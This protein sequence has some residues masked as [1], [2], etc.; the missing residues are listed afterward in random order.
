MKK[1]N[2]AYWVLT[3]L[4]AAFVMMSVIPNIMV[5]KGSVDMIHGMM[6]YPIYLIRFLGVAKLLAVIGILVPGFP[7]IKEWSYAGIL[8]DL[9]GATYSFIAIGTPILDLWMLFL[10]IIVLFASYFLHLE[11]LKA[12]GRNK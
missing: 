5:D 7:R 12:A 4:L 3:I 2:I 1:V 10:S 8:F 9:V 11:R 6:G